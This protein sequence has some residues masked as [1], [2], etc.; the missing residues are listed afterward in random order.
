MF[1]QRLFAIVLLLAAFAV[2][3]FVYSTEVPATSSVTAT[4]TPP[5]AS[6]FA[7]KLGLDLNG[8]SHLVY[9][10][11]ITKV[12]PAD[13]GSSMSALRDV[14]ENRVNT[15]GVSEPLVQVESGGVG[16][17]I[18]QKLIVEL[19]GVT[20][21]AKAIELIGKTP[22]LEFRLAREQAPAKGAT[23][24][25]VFFEDTGIT[26]RLVQRAQ[27]QFNQTTGAPEVLLQFN[28]EGKD[29]FAKVTRENVG[30]VLGIFLDGSPISLPV[31]R[32]EIKD[33]QANI[34][35][36]FTPDE[37]KL[38]VRDLNYGALPV[39]I[40]L[41]STQ[42]VGASLGEGALHGG[43]Q[44][45]IWSFIIIALFLILWYR[46]PGLLAV[47]ALGVYTAIMLVLFKLIP[48][49]LTAA[50]IAGFILSIGMAVDANILIFER[51]KEEF[52]KGGNVD[53]VMR[54]GFSRAWSSIRDSNFSS[55]ITAV[56]L[57]WFS[58]TSI[59]KGF[60]LIFGMGVLVSMFTAITVT[61]TF[62]FAVSHK[63]HEGAARFL[64]G[65]GMTNS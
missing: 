21:I 40:E 31:I 36:S 8:G 65:S 25:A 51:M 57:F 2:G 10:A 37:A 11:D 55:I 22:L 43:V 38:L 56:I 32:E 12:V 60:A 6:R 23:T 59:V 45:G 7:F 46:L 14:I 49:T 5:V 61:R 15:F 44:A 16:S 42:K 28:S 1:R 48:V 3:Y 54:E 34:S 9:K 53:G 30:T 58:N 64:F 35:G 17:T 41:I 63:R 20:D 29:L 39:P 52:R 62:L 47:V 26:G 33:G 13:V 19:P 24:T 18:D 50:G 27:V 4:S